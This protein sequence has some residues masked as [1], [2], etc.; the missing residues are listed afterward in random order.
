M[1]KEEHKE[2]MRKHVAFLRSGRIPKGGFDM[3]CFCELKQ[4]ISGIAKNTCGTVG[5]NLGWATISIRPLN[6]QELRLWHF[7]LIYSE[8]SLNI[9]GFSR[10]SNVDLWR[11]FFSAE[12]DYYAPSEFAAA[13]RM[14]YYLDHEKI[15]RF[16][17]I[18]NFSVGQQE[19]S[20]YCRKKERGEV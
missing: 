4:L 8:F 20:E 3:G 11:W 14:E 17:K 9:F 7:I 19:A 15:P 5:C 13:D 10:D 12:W 18:W 6:R 16:E 1:I 2:N